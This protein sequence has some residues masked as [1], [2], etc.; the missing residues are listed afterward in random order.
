MAKQYIVTLS[1]KSVTVQRLVTEVT[2]PPDAQFLSTGANPAVA[3]A[4]VAQA[5]YE[6]APA[7]T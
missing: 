4:A 2:V 7:T 1:G 6:D 3:G 5:L